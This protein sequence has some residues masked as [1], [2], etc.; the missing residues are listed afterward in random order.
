[1]RFSDPD[2]LHEVEQVVRDELATN[3]RP[4]EHRFTARLGLDVAGIHNDSVIAAMA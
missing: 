2:F 1:V 4:C 3:R